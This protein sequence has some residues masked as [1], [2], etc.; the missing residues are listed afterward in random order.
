MPT[1]EPYRRLSSWLRQRFGGQIRKIPLDGGGTCPNRDGTLGTGGCIFCNAR[2]SGTGLAA[3]G[4]SLREQYTRHWQRLHGKH[5]PRGAIAYLQSYS[6][7]HGPAARLAHIL[8]Q[9]K[10]LPGLVGVAVGTRP[11]CL[12][13]EKWAMLRHSPEPIVWLELGL[14][15][16]HNATLQRIHRGH[17][18]ETFATACHMAARYGIPVCAHIIAGLPG[19]TRQHWHQTIAYLN[20]LPIHGVKIHNLFVAQGTALESLWRQGHIALLSFEETIQWIADA[21]ALLRPD[22]IIHRLSADP[23]PGELIAP[24]FAGEKQRL[25]HAVH[26]YLSRHHITQGCWGPGQP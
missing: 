19:E 10:G 23:Q 4:L 25:L 5:P 26:D 8:D 12:D 1:S 6:T 20:A 15:S 21:V 22:I 7:T 16:A 9:L 3:A 14:Q 2:G 11:D 13:P 18:A 17:N 24:E